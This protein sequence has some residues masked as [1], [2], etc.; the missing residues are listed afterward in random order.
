MP[1]N[2]MLD[3]GNLINAAPCRIGAR[4][5][6]MTTIA[7]GADFFAVRNITDLLTPSNRP[8]AVSQLRVN[9]S[10]ITPF[11]N[12]QGLAFEFYKVTAFTAIHSGGSG[13]VPVAKRRKTTGYN[14]IPSTEISVL[15]SD[16]AA[17]TTA[18][19]TLESDSMPF[20]VMACDVHSIGTTGAVTC[21]VTWRPADNLPEVFEK[22]EGIIG[23]ITN[24]MGAA[25]VIRAFVGVDPRNRMAENDGTCSHTR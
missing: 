20:A 7:A 25:G 5:G 11:T 23:R 17:I 19:Y 1:S 21:N 12:A 2:M 22:D 18:T 10:T 9:A 16:T 8:M 15:I 6:L 3:S 24:T 14:A 13:L 4:S